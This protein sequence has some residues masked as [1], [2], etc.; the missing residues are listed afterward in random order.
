MRPPPVNQIIQHTL[1]I[2]LLHSKEYTGF[3][4]ELF[5]NARAIV[6][7]CLRNQYVCKNFSKVLLDFLA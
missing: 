5:Y 2:V 3:Y 7:T 1:K 6:H 4:E